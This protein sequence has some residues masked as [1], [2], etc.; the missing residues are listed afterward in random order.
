[1]VNPWAFRFCYAFPSQVYSRSPPE[2]S[3]GK[4]QPDSSGPF[5][6]LVL[7]TIPTLRPS[8]FSSREA[9]FNIAG[10]GVASPGVV[11]KP[12]SLASDEQLLK[13]PGF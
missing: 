10:S 3:V 2:I 9:G 4:G 5:L 6:A 13:S 12:G 1:M 8:S 7:T 11:S